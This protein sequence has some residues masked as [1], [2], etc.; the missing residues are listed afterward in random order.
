MPFNRRIIELAF[1]LTINDSNKSNQ[2][3]ILE[4]PS[5]LIVGLIID[6]SYEHIHIYGIQDDWYL[7][8]TRFGCYKCDQFE[9]LK[10]FFDDIETIFINACNNI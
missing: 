10:K 9:G 5:Y 8:K 3:L 2:K 7:I 4:S 1:D 6:Y